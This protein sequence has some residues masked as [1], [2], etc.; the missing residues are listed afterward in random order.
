MNRKEM[1]GLFVGGI[2]GNILLPGVGAYIGVEVADV[3]QQNRA[4]KRCEEINECLKNIVEFKEV[5]KW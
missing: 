1:L 5:T 2:L 4:E 3:I